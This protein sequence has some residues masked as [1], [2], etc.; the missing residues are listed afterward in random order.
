VNIIFNLIFKQWTLP[1]VC[2]RKRFALPFFLIVFGLTACGGGGG[3]GS[4]STPAKTAR[5]CGTQTGTGCASASSRVDL[6]EPVFSANS[7]KITNPLNPVSEL[8]SGVFLGQ[9]DGLPF[10]TETT[11]L[12]N[13]RI[14]Q[15]NGVAVETLVY[16]YMAFSDG[17]LQEVAIDYFAEDVNKNVWY[18]GEDV[19]DYDENGRVTTNEGT[20]FFGKD[21]APLAMIMAANPKVGNV[22]LAEDTA[23]AAWEEVTVTQVD[24]S[25]DGPSGALAGGLLGSELHMDGTRQDKVFM[26]GYGEFKTG[27]LQ[28]DDLEALALTLPIDALQGAV[29]NEL[30]VMSS[31]SAA[32]FNAASLNDFASAAASFTSVSSAWDSYQTGQVPPLLKAEMTR[33]LALLKQAVEEQNVGEATDE[34]IQL[35]RVIYDLRLRYEPITEIDQVRLD[36]WMAQVAVDAAQGELGPILGDAVTAALVFNRFRHALASSLSAD[37]DS[38][39]SELNAAAQANDAARAAFAAT[40]IRGVLTAGWK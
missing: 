31:A 38:K 39:L 34:A 10:R 12:P 1:A 25:A 19:A 3:G 4:T 23:P 20:W 14:V 6:F 26:P 17:R 15:V 37:I 36:L 8:K 9:V 13:T 40:Q 29:P 21:N 5:P 2:L 18:F 30:K 28:T 24:V 33:Q 32:L 35:A 27:S 16:Q 7:A 22:W 11:V